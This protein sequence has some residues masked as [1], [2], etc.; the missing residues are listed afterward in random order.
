MPKWRRLPINGL[1]VSCARVRSSQR[2]SGRTDAE[3]KAIANQ[4]PLHSY[5]REGRAGEEE[6]RER[7]LAAEQAGVEVP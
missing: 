4:E 2:S 3:G 5:D 7:I 1:P 6:L